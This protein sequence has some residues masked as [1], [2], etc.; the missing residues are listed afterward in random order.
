MQIFGEKCLKILLD[1]LFTG[2]PICITRITAEKL[3]QEARAN[4]LLYFCGRLN[5]ERVLKFARFV[6]SSTFSR[7]LRIP[8]KY[9]FQKSLTIFFKLTDRWNIKSEDNFGRTYVFGS[10]T[11]YFQL[12]YSRGL[13]S[14]KVRLVLHLSKRFL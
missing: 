9:Q 6:I 5:R 8:K 12:Y 1:K 2:L 3:N 7:F 13:C 4:Q 14:I 11:K 10:R